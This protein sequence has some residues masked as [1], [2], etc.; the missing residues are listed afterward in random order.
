M[1]AILRLV[2]RDKFYTQER[3]I[4]TGN[5]PFLPLEKCFR[6]FDFCGAV[7]HPPGPTVSQSVVGVFGKSTVPVMSWS[8]ARVWCMCAVTHRDGEMIGQLYGLFW[9]RVRAEW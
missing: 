5:S 3:E 8:T 9:T 6:S 4:Y 1:Q 7:P 2:F